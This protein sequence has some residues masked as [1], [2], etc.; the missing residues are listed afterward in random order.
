MILRDVEA[1]CVRELER[2]EG[3]EAGRV[4]ELLVRQH[5][6]GS[7]KSFDTTGPIFHSF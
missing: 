4:R 7:Q 3:V 1:A 6:A 5:L 2:R